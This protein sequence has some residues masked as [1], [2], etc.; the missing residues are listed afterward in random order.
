MR[1]YDGFYFTLKKS[2]TLIYPIS[3][4]K[5]YNNNEFNFFDYTIKINKLEIND[6]EVEDPSYIDKTY[7]G[8]FLWKTTGT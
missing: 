5:T 4:T 8:I 6:D 3:I 2:P 1:Y 7:K